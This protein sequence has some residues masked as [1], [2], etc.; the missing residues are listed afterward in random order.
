MSDTENKETPDGSTDVS[1]A[2][3]DRT[4]TLGSG[5]S[6]DSSQNDE[7]ADT[8]SGGPPDE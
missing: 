7:Q 2:E 4:N 8:A 3:K 1:E 6:T 5:A